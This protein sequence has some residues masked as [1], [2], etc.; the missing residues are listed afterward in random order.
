MKTRSRRARLGMAVPAVV[1]GLAFLAGCTHHG[2]PGGGHEH[3]GPG[4]PGGTG[5]H[6]TITL[7][8]RPTTTRGPRPTVT[9]PPRP[10]TT[11]D[12]GHGDHGD[13]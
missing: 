3:G 9:V 1:A 7:P 4:G 13:H 11:A 12:P 8:S 10:T 5:P 6:P 2:P